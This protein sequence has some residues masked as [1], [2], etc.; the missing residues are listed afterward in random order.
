MKSKMLKSIVATLLSAAMLVSLAA[1][2]ESGSDEE[3][4]ND[5]VGESVS[6][7]ADVNSDI[8]DDS[9]TDI[10][11]KNNIPE[12]IEPN[13]PV[14]CDFDTTLNSTIILGDNHCFSVGKDGTVTAHYLERHDCGLDVSS[15]TDIVAIAECGVDD[16][17]GLKS[18]GT[19]VVAGSSFE[20]NKID[21]SNWN[22]IIQIT[23]GRGFLAGLKSD[24]TV[25]A[26]GERESGWVNENVNEVATWNDIVYISSSSNG[27][28]IAGV[29]SN[30][31]VV[32]TGVGDDILDFCGKC[33]E[34]LTWR[35]IVSISVSNGNQ[36]VGLKA[37]GTVVSTGVDCESCNDAG[38]CNVS[39]WADIVA[40]AVSS[41]H[42]V[43]LKADGTVVAIGRNVDDECDVSEW[44]DIVAVS[45]GS[46]GT[47]GLKNDGTVV[48]KG[49]S[50]YISSSLRSV[51][52]RIPD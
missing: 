49:D 37:D 39:D 27:D 5:S 20:A 33:S 28:I 32:I 45:A 23:A 8:D 30:G 43:G 3:K 26:T 38:Q 1:C 6:D 46:Y 10:T 21:A 36:I 4:K 7:G 34:V 42:T 11:H 40:V 15:W 16:L 48:T 9:S 50:D 12:Y 18:D 51:D 24:G 44:T 14:E 19:V 17:A 25:V 22:N 13:V 31:T 41:F 29:K 47:V 35:N 2:G 52:V